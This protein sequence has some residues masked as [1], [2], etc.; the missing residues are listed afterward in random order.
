V[1][2]L[3]G[4]SWG[5]FEWE[6]TLDRAAEAIDWMVRRGWAVMFATR[7]VADQLGMSPA[8]LRSHLFAREAAR[9]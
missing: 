7:A 4:G 6:P 2:T 1:K 8:Q 5:T 9:L 3:G